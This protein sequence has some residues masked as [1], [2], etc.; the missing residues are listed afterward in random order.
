MGFSKGGTDGQGPRGGAE[1]REPERERERRLGTRWRN[2]DRGKSHQVGR[3][4]DEGQAEGQN[5]GHRGV[6]GSGVRGRPPD[7]LGETVSSQ[8]P[9]TAA[10]P[11]TAGTGT[12]LHNLCSTGGCFHSQV[13][14]CHCVGALK[15]E[16]RKERKKKR[17]RQLNELTQIILRDEETVPPTLRINPSQA[18][19]H[20][21]A[22]RWFSSC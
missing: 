14:A 8:Q 3:A 4:R 12:R 21:D 16:E 6:L 17:K 7:K 11:S 19:H 18:A 9:R 1:G 20:D 13:A 15:G 2:S 10:P 5:A 22:V